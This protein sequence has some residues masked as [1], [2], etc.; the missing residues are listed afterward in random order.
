M[1]IWARRLLIVAVLDI[2]L[3]FS[4]PVGGTFKSFWARANTYIQRR[5][6]RG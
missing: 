3:E 6:R 4:P 1:S 2:G 5:Q